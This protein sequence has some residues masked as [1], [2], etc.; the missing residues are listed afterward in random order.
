[1]G[2]FTELFIR[3]RPDAEAERIR[4]ALCFLE[5]MSPADCADIAVKP[6]DFPRIAREMAQRRSL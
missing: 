5:S 3:P 6:A 2:F 1:M 4:R